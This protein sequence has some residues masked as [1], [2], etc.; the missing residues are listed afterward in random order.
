MEN[1]L[2]EHDVEDAIDSDEAAAVF[3]TA[4]Y[5]LLGVNE[6]ITIIYNDEIVIVHKNIDLDDN[7]RINIDYFEDAV[8]LEEGQLVVLQYE[9][10]DRIGDEDEVATII[11]INAPA[12]HTIH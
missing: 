7:H 6:G 5:H 1:T 2:V 11:P 10:G 4:L 8:G 12:D 3:G 9:N